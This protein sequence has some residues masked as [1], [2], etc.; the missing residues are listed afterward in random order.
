M[1]SFTKPV[2]GWLGLII[3][4]DKFNC[5]SEISDVGPDSLRE[6][7]RAVLSLQSIKAKISVECNLEPTVLMLTFTNENPLLKVYISEDKLEVCSLQF[8]LD[9][10]LAHLQSELDRIEPLCTDENWTA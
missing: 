2:H 1:I 4:S 5:T 10:C 6:F 3:D 9:I 8:P 7:R